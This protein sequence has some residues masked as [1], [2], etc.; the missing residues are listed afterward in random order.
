MRTETVK[1]NYYEFNLIT[2]KALKSVSLGFSRPKIRNFTT[3][4]LSLLY[5]Y[6]QTL[7]SLSL[8]IQITA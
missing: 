5:T 2:D 3:R 7:C 6:M 1:M 8:A 4:S